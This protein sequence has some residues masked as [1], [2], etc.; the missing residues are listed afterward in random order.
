[1]PREEHLVFGALKK[2]CASDGYAHVLAYLCFRDNTIGYKDHIDSDSYINMFSSNRLLRTEIS[3][4]IGLMFKSEIGLSVPTPDVMQDLISRTDGLLRELHEA[5]NAPL[6]EELHATLLKNIDFNPFRCGRFL[7]EPIFYGPE[8]AYDFQYRDFS[9][10]KY[11]NDNDWMKSNKG[12]SIEEAIETVSCIS[13]IQ[14]TKIMETLKGLKRKNSN[15]WTM[16]PAYIVVPDEIA[17][18]SELDLDTVRKVLSAFSPPPGDKNE[19]F[20]NLSDFNITNAYPLICIADNQYLLFQNYS[21]AEALYETP[22]YWMSADKCYVNQAMHNRGKF[23]ENFSSDRLEIVFGKHRV[24]RNINIIDNKKQVASEIDVFVVYAD[25]AIIL[26][27]KSKRLT[28]ESKKGNDLC[29][30]DDFKKS[31][32]DSYN[33]GF[34]CAKL[35]SDVSYRLVNSNG[36]PI[37]IPRKFSEIYIFCLL[38]DHYP[39]LS[40]QAQ[41]FLKHKKTDTILPPFILDVFCLDVITEFLSSPLR[42]LSYINRRVLY[43]DKIFATHEIIILSYHLRKNL[44]IE[45]DIDQLYIDDSITADLDLSMLARRKGLPAPSIPAGILTKFKNSIIDKIITQIEALDEPAAIDLGFIIFT[46]NE[47]TIN[48]INDGIEKISKRARY[49]RKPHDFTIG[50]DNGSSGL[51]IHCNYHP[52][53]ISAQKLDYHCQRR[54]YI[55]KSNTWFGFS[56][57]PDTFS[58]NVV[59]KLAYKWKKS[60]AMDKLI[61]SFSRISSNIKTSK[62]V[63]RND[64]CPCGSGLKYKKCCLKVRGV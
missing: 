61:K 38:S 21:L 18:H 34:E 24:F 31:I 3:T 4:L 57:N 47:D 44:W 53:N 22:F 25:R 29:I 27:A 58:I 17:H 12:F 9:R 30:Q 28:I 16:L 64:P 56:I 39:S 51:T 6:I 1:M 55:S 50:L 59:T 11:E 37:N 36:T 41:Q 32:Q 10:Q 8:S 43:T 7:R 5:M 45:E 52:A 35:L 40:F 2:L 14:N 60:E 54:K 46:L 20:N 63:G 26:Q 13:E 42:F 19:N 15:S 48:Q 62:K 33:Q 49:D 23:A